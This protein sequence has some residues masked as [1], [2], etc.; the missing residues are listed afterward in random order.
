M[1]YGFAVVS[2]VIGGVEVIRKGEPMG[3]LLIFSATL[4]LA[5]IWLGLAYAAFAFFLAATYFVWRFR[6]MLQR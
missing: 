2:N 5:A 4:W 3:W 1:I 6:A